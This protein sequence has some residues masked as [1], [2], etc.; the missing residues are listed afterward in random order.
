L[1]AGYGLTAQRHRH[2]S[3]K[4]EDPVRSTLAFVAALAA[5]GALALGVYLFRP[6]AEPTAPLIAPTVAVAAEPTAEAAEPTAPAAATAEPTAPAAAT[7]VPTVVAAATA[8]PT[9]EPQSRARS[10][11]IDAAASTAR[12]LLDEVLRGSPFTVVGETRDVAGTILLDPAA[13]ASAQVGEI[14]INARTLQTDSGFRDRAIQNAVLRTDRFEL[15]RLQPTALSGLPTT[16]EVGAAYQFT[17]QGDLT[18]TDVTRPVEFSVEVTAENEATLRGRAEATIAWR[19]FNL[20]IPDSPSVNSV[21]DT[22]VLQFDFTARAA[23]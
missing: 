7:A 3:K 10:Y 23:P 9:A 13:P 20:S 14:L 5:A 1:D 18:I 19:D 2:S 15:I 8:A 22:M 6:P 16:A 12:F 21:E 11:T 17:L 4:R